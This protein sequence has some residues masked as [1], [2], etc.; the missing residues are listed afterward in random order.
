MKEVTVVDD[1]SVKYLRW[2]EDF[3]S[4]ERMLK[5]TAH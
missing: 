1:S 4:E 5:V 3:P 2:P